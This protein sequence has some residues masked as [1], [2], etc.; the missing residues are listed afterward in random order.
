MHWFEYNLW[1]LHSKNNLFL[2]DKTGRIV[3]LPQSIDQNS[4]EQ[5]YIGLHLIKQN[6]LKFPHFRTSR[7]FRD[8]RKSRKLRS[9]HK[10][11]C[12]LRCS[13]TH[14]KNIE[15]QRYWRPHDELGI[16]PIPSLCFNTAMRISCLLDICHSQ[17]RDMSYPTSITSLI[18][19]KLSTFKTKTTSRSENRD[20]C[21]N[22]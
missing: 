6:V 12:I 18:L 9:K 14:D 13:R 17:R 11:A 1:P 5:M 4:T 8:R 16:A 7:K 22:L 15:S 10:D 3:W 20:S 2:L 19:F 21:S